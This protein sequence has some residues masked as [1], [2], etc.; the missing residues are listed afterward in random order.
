MFILHLVKNS[1]ILVNEDRSICLPIVREI[2]VND[3]PTFC[4]LFYYYLIIMRVYSDP[5]N[6]IFQP[7]TLTFSI[8]IYLT[9][10]F[11]SDSINFLHRIRITTFIV[12][13]AAM[14]YLFK[15]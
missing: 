7:L 1:P 15:R 13:S 11:A 10:I 3:I 4:H 9:L 14:F 12:Y 5:T 6:P 8:G 2:S